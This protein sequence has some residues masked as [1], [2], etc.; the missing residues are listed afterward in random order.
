M[1]CLVTARFWLVAWAAQAEAGALHPTLQELPSWT[2][3]AGQVS[4]VIDSR[5]LISTEV[6]VGQTRVQHDPKLWDLSVSWYTAPST[7]AIVYRACSLV[8]IC[9]MHSQ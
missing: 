1:A 7:M 5:I 3:F 6:Y 9:S 4:L 8:S 2:G